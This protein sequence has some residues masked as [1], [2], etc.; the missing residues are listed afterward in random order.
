MNLS[1]GFIGIV[2]ALGTALLHFVWQGVLVSVCYALLRTL[3]TGIAA[4]YRLGLAALV[5]LALCPV[6]TLIYVWPAAD[7]VDG[8]GAA[9][10]LGASV[11]AVADRAAAHWQLHEAL[12][13]LVAGWLCGVVALACRSLWH[14]RRLLRLVREASLPPAEWCE[15]LVRLCRQFGLR[16]PVR[17]LCSARAVTP[18]LIG[19][20][21]PVV[22]LPASMLSGFTP[23]QVE[24]IIAHELGHVCRWDYLANL[25]QVVLETVLFYHPVVHWISRDVRNAR[26]SCCDDLVL[27]L[28]KGNALTYARTLADL[29]ELRHEEA[30]M[31]PALGASGGV[32]LA[33]IRHIVGVSERADPLPRTNM[34]P[35]LFLLAA[36]AGLAWRQHTL[37]TASPPQTLIEAPAQT[38]ALVSGNPQL[39]FVA[40]QTAPPVSVRES[41]PAETARDTTPAPSTVK[42]EQPHATVV[43]PG[44]ERVRN[45][46]AALP[47]TVAPLQLAEA[48][49]GEPLPAAAAEAAKLVPL[50]IVSPVYPSR[51]MASGVEGN[52]ELEFGID[53]SGLVRDIRVLRAQPAGVFDAAAK[54][55]L[56]EWRFAPTSSAERHT[57]NFAF[58]LHG[59]GADEANAKC[60]QLTGSMICRRPGE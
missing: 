25:F 56:G 46:A 60:Q 7:A 34:W 10:A 12:P 2:D 38:L 15:R 41:T 21:K 43:T 32:L 1:A 50:H 9:S 52:V 17:L 26:E 51:A 20:I 40:P 6:A 36:I 29:E 18:M 24:L 49:A 27:S 45:L 11:L 47:S 48:E 53:E 30:V 44:L 22:L 19:W 23:Q 4:R 14:W 57:Q 33:R 13:W 31:A 8:G 35:L 16:R 58:T 37:Q 55:A 28:A 3:Y 54:A 5:A 42:I 39:R 59:R